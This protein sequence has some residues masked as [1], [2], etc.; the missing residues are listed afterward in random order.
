MKQAENVDDL[1]S[2]DCLVVTAISTSIYSCVNGKATR[3]KFI[4]EDDTVIFLH[5]Y[6]TEGDE[7]GNTPFWCKIFFKGDVYLESKHCI[8]GSYKKVQ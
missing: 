2:G 8:T 6:P 4:Y 3:P 7:P 5:A 1:L